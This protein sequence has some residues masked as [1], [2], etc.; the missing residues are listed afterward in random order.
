MIFQWTKAGLEAIL[1]LG[2]YTELETGILH[3]YSN[4]IGFDWLRAIGDLTE[5]N[6]TGYVAIT[7]LAVATTGPYQDPLSNEIYYKLPMASMGECTAVPQTIYG[8]YVTDSAGT[9]V[10]GMLVFDAP[11]GVV[12]NSTPRLNV[13]FPFGEGTELSGSELDLS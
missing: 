6:Y 5:A 10:Y 8:A 2:W 12:V 3:L 9:V 1:G 11:M 13:L 7:A 4:N